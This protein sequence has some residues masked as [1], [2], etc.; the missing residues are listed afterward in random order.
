MGAVVR[1]YGVRTEVAEHMM[2]AIYN[3]LVQKV[4]AT[5]ASE[6]T[7]KFLRV[8]LDYPVEAKSIIMT[9]LVFTVGNF[10]RIAKDE[11][12]ATVG[13]DGMMGDLK[14]VKVGYST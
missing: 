2:T 8:L 11:F 5:P 14:P 4:A 7:D 13:E 12:D 3:S 1:T 6:P 10:D 9:T